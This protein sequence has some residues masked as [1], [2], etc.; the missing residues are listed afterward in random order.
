MVWYKEQDHCQGLNNS[1]LLKQAEFA[2]K[3][4]N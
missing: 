3:M 2:V 4:A 1:I